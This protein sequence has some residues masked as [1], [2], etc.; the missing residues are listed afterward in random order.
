MSQFDIVGIAEATQS[1]FQATREIAQA[2][3]HAQGGTSTV[4]A[5]AKGQWGTTASGSLTN[6]NASL[7]N[8]YQTAA[9]LTGAYQATNGD[10]VNRVLPQY[11][12]VLGSV[13]AAPTANRVVL[14]NADVDG[15]YAQLE[16]ARAELDRAVEQA[17]ASLAGL[18]DSW[19]ISNSLSS[20]TSGYIHWYSPTTTSH[21]RYGS[22]RGTYQDVEDEAKYR[23]KQVFHPDEV[24]ESD[25]RAAAARKRRMANRGGFFP[26]FDPAILAC[27]SA[28]SMYGSSMKCSLNN[29]AKSYPYM[30]N[31]TASGTASPESLKNASLDKEEWEEL[32]E[33]AKDIIDTVLPDEY[34]DILGPIGIGIDA[35]RAEH[36]DDPDTSAEDV[37]GDATVEYILEMIAIDALGAGI[38]GATLFVFNYIYDEMK[39]T[40]DSGEEFSV[41]SKAPKG[42]GTSDG[43]YD[44]N[45]YVKDHPGP[46]PEERAARAKDNTE[47]A[48]EACEGY[49]IDHTAVER[50]I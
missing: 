49:G 39:E 20:A 25:K 46:T 35:A 32:Y 21:D 30:A 41:S 48:K 15:S 23:F 16:E 17:Q 8:L 19:P 3:A 34:N 45:E 6:T 2:L 9:Q 14:E 37:L 28:G 26:Y 4:M 47:R 50:P 18:D 40:I 33:D 10:L 1:S 7:D 11:R 13:G 22:Y 24:T 38:G 42:T 5:T 31:P 29:M 36:D 44:V 12:E 43:T 27:S